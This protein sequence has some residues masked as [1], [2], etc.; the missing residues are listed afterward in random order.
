MIGVQG[1]RYKALEFSGEVVERLPMDDSFT[2]A[3]MAVVSLLSAAFTGLFCA[4]FS[5]SFVIPDAQ[6]GV[7]LA[8]L[9]ILC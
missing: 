9:G 2:I 4:G 8:A 3:N 1:A 6:T 7:I 5:I